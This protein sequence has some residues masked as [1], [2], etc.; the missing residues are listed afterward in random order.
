EKV[1]LN[2]VLH[3]GSESELKGRTDAAGFI[4]SML[5]A[6]TSKH[7][8]R[9]IQD[10]IDKLKANVRISGG[11]AF[12]GRRNFTGAGGAQP[13]T[14]DV[15]IETMRGNLPAVIELVGELLR[16]SNFPE[17]EFEKER[18]Q[19]LANLE[20]QLSEPQA[21]APTEMRRRLAPY[22]PDDIRYVP[23]IPERIE[24]IKAVKLDDVKHL[25]KELVGAGYAEAAVVG[26]FDPAEIT[27]SLN[28]AL[29]NW[30]S[31]KPFE[32]ITM[33]YREAKPDTLAI[34]TPDKAN[35][36]FTM[37]MNIA[38]RD[39]DP[40]YP[41]IFMADY[42]LGG[43][44]SSRL[45]NRIRQKEGLSYG[46]RSN[47]QASP[48]EPSGNISAGGICAPQN[49]QKALACAREEIERLIKEGVTQ[50]ELDDARQGYLEDLK[51]ALS[52]DAGLAGMLVRNLYLER[53]MKFT[54]ERIAKIKA[55]TPDDIKAAA[56]KYMDPD[57]MVVISA[58]DFGP[59]Q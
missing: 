16:E 24:R 3:Y 57:K 28:S 29:A 1:H 36:L 44:G 4:S 7:S 27:S 26:D 39:D 30:K 59:T 10:T 19:A 50:T 23:T 34:S 35:S 41:A 6:G 14:I 58:G 12:G 5:T 33:P 20:Q 18:T 49:T 52:N 43:G 42:I 17:S 46:V 40:D 15:S 21:L 47:L 22:R 13:G 25:Y 8:R 2:L 38:I 54:E 56:R 9:E 53:T 55:L 48:H 32:R 51:V 11:G 45:T 31:N 37:G